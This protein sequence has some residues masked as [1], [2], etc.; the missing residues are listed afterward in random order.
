MSAKIV[1][2]TRNL[3]F[4]EVQSGAVSAIQAYK[5]Q[6]ME[7]VIGPAKV[8]AAHLP[9]NTDHGMAILALELMFFEPHGQF[10]NPATSGSRNK[11]CTAFDRFREYL[12]SHSQIL[13]DTDRLSSEKIY[14]WARC[15]LF[16]SSLL[17]SDLL[18]D[19]VEFS[20]RPLAK[21][22]V[23]EGWLVDP[24]LLLGCL[25][26][27]LGKYV[28]EI[29]GNPSGILATHFNSTFTTLFNEPLERF[30]KM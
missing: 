14:K 16:H 25:E 15:G 3:G 11:F 28:S 30:S 18:V 9:R 12:K 22:T 6:V 21:N 4:D 13:E 7:W 24:W 20:G 10:L 29:E 8:L 17:A 27:Y 2:I 19:A 26:N 23:L 5:T 1:R